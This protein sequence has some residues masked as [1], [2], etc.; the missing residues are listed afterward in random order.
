[1]HICSTRCS[2]QI[3]NPMTDK[4]AAGGTCVYPGGGGNQCRSVYHS[5]TDVTIL[6]STPR[7]QYVCPREPPLGWIQPTTAVYVCLSFGFQYL[8]WYYYYRHQYNNTCIHLKK[9][10]EGCACCHQPRQSPANGA[11]SVSLQSL[12]LG[13]FF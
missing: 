8:R 1:M 2:L 10:T 3:A 12:F 11:F 7:A 5:C 13:G 9:S 6:G 4:I